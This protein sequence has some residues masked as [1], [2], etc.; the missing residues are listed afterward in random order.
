MQ[1]VPLTFPPSIDSDISGATIP[2]NSEDQ[3]KDREETAS[4][5]HPQ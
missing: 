4:R 5:D 1:P 3:V 2:E